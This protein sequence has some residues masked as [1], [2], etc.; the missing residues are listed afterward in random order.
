[1]SSAIA[2]ALRNTFGVCEPTLFVHPRQYSFA[3][4]PWIQFPNERSWDKFGEPE[5]TAFFREVFE[6]EQLF[7]VTAASRHR[8]GALQ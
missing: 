1:M 8:L 7:H 4:L 6:L 2:V 5:R 3:I